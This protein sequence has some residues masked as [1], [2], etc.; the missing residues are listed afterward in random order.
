LFLKKSAT[1]KETHFLQNSRPI[2]RDRR[3][4]VGLSAQVKFKVKKN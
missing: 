3:L 1:L 2:T 4:L